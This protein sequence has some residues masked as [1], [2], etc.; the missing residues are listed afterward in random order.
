M[1]NKILSA[2]LVQVV[3]F[4]CAFSLLGQQEPQFTQ[5]WNTKNYF[6]PATVGLNYKHQATLLARN[7]WINYSGNPETQLA[8]YS[9]KM[10]KLHGGIG[11]NYLHDKI[12][13]SEINK[14]K[15]NYSYQF[16]CKNEG[17]LSFGLAV[18]MQHFKLTPTWITPTTNP[19]QNL[20]GAISDAQFTSDFGIAY[21]NERLNVGLSVTQLN[22]ARYTGN[23][24]TFQ[25][26]RHYFFFAD[27][28]FGNS[29]KFQI[30]PQFFYR[31]DASFQTLEINTLLK[32]KS[33]YFIGAT[34]RS[35]D[36]FALMAGWDIKQKFRIS[37][38]YDITVSKLNNSNTGGS[39]EFVLGLLLK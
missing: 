23:N 39:H 3:L 38:S 13:F 21:S 7:Q 26:T 17:V 11:V 35:R 34:Y 33:T 16:V 30:V 29:E 4:F 8:S 32:Y 2:I 14:V 10:D 15:L 9:M 20:P 28:A 1:K 22:E 18:G 27:Y 19:D 31:T 36:A 6:N 25:D 37:Y 12:G 24:S 5:F